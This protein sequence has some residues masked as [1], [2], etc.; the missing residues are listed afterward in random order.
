MA[1][2]D[3]LAGGLVMATAVVT[4]PLASTAT[5]AAGPLIDWGTGSRPRRMGRAGIGAGSFARSR[6]G[7]TGSGRSAGSRPG[8]LGTGLGVLLGAGI[9]LPGAGVL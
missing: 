5:A 1:L 7:R 9:G 4:L 2:L 3:K 6:L 8:R